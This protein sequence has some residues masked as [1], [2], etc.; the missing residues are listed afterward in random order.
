MLTIRLT[1]ILAVLLCLGCVFAGN[2]YAAMEDEYDGKNPK[3]HL[4]LN[5]YDGPSTCAMCHPY[6]AKEVAVSIHYQQRSHISSRIELQ[7]DKF[8][9]M[10]ENY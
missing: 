2:T 10:L 1:G 7:K 6:A 9:G 8:V 5:D 4:V 3:E